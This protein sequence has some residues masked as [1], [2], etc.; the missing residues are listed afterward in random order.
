[1]RVARCFTQ[2]RGVPQPQEGGVHGK[3]WSGGADGGGSSAMTVAGDM[4]RV[5]GQVLEEATL[6]GGGKVAAVTNEP[7]LANVLAVRIFMAGKWYAIFFVC[8]PGL[9][10]LP[11]LRLLY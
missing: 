2:P 8:P 11:W 3:G 4:L 6:L 7:A 10:C 9:V 1:M 5:M